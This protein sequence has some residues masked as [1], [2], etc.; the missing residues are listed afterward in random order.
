MKEYLQDFA[1]L[2]DVREGDHLKFV[3]GTPVSEKEVEE[4][5]G[6]RPT[7][8]QISRYVGAARKPAPRALRQSDEV[9]GIPATHQERVGELLERGSLWRL[10]ED[11]LR[12]LL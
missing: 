5:I 12:D 6:A 10:S 11:E 2:Y 4:A 1:Y 3:E 7:W 8:T 9:R